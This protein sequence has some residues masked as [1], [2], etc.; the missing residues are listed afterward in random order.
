[1]T[2]LVE[3]QRALRQADRQL[4]IDLRHGLNEAAQIV[5]DAATARVPKR[6]GRLAASIRPLSTQREGRVVMGTVKRVPYAGWIEF[7]GN[8]RNKG[9]NPSRRPFVKGGRFLFPAFR[10]R[11]VA[12]RAKLEAVLDRMA[13]RLNGR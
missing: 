13:E 9:G 8:K 11:R 12:V 4:A 6:T 2:G 7:G 10:D 1:M 5:D 3:F